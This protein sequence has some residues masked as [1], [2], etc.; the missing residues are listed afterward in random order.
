MSFKEFLYSM[1]EN[2]SP[3]ALEDKN[4]LFHFD[5]GPSEEDQIT[6]EAKDGKITVSQGLNGEALCTIKASEETLGKI[7]N[8][9]MNPMTAMMMGKIKVSNLGELMKYASTFGIL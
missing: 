7:I 5:M 9:E 2:I 8:K 6:V 4:T 3:A 1:P